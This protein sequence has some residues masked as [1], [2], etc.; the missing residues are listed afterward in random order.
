VEN[1]QLAEGRFSKTPSDHPLTLIPGRH[2]PFRQHSNPLRDKGQ[3]LPFS[4]SN[5]PAQQG[6]RVTSPSKLD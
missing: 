2:E 5:R 6:R 1:P 4:A 3:S